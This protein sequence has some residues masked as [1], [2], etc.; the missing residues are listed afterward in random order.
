[1]VK[2]GFS[3]EAAAD[4]MCDFFQ[5]AGLS[6]MSDWTCEELNPVPRKS[7]SSLSVDGEDFRYFGSADV[8]A[9]LENIIDGKSVWMLYDFYLRERRVYKHSTVWR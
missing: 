6:D 3:C 9:A 1:M 5:S 4:M 8:V 7:E 2:S